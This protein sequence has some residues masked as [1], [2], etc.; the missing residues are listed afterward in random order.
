MSASG[1]RFAQ[2]PLERS[3]AWQALR[4]HR[5]AFDTP[6]N[7][8]FERDPGR[9]ERLALE[10]AGFYFD[11]SKQRVD[12]RALSLLLDLA[13]ERDL[14]QWIE[15]LFDG[16]PVNATEGRPALHM[17]LRAQPGDGVGRADG[18]VI[19]QVQATLQRMERFV[20]Q[21]RNGSWT[22]VG[23]KPI[24]DVVNIG[25]GGS[26]LG[27]RL[28]CEALSPLADGPR[29]HF[30]STVDGAHVHG[31]LS[32]LDPATTLFVVTSKSFSTAETLANAKVARQWIE[33]A[34]GAEGVRRHMVAV[35]ANKTAVREFGLD[36]EQ[37]FEFW[38]WVGGRYSLWSAVGLPVAISIG[39]PNFRRLLAGARAM[40]QHFLAAPLERNMPALLGLIGIWNRHFQGFGSQIVVP[41][42]RLFERLPAYLQQLEM[43]SNGKGVT[44]DGRFVDYP[45]VPAI[46][47]GAGTDTQHAFFQRLHQGPDALP[48]DIILPLAAEPG[49]EALQHTLVANAL[50]QGEA[51]MR[52]KSAA[53]VRAELEAQGLSDD[54]LE[55]AIPHRQFPGNRPTSTLL[56]PD[57]GPEALGALIALY[58]HKVFVQSVIWDINAFDQWGVELGK[59]LAKALLFA[60]DSKSVSDHDA[61]TQ[62]LLK[63]FLKSL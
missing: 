15:R 52:G 11:F 25:I 61:S 28:A 63:R 19:A 58:E 27:P 20:G 39:M 48:V 17:A 21:V 33:Q 42:S 54:A 16:E 57:T 53:E 41:Y 38:D 30:L 14:K 3:D 56:M 7:A 4:A 22:G 45:T 18:D 35:S 62:R 46:W 34:A 23:G 26:D 8:L 51:L 37:A 5:D 40:D 32:R 49:Y 59:T 2:P 9:A 36:D 6:L 24:A 44:R 47:G 43:E 1:R 10:A 55:M 60:M 29:V 12:D 31:V 50:A 13:R